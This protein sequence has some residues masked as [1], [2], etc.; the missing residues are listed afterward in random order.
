MYIIDIVF[1]FIYVA[2]C[3]FCIRETK[4]ITGNLISITNMF[5]IPYMLIC[6]FQEVICI[7][8]AYF[9]LPSY[10]YWFINS[11]F[12][13]LTYFTEI[14]LTKIFKPCSRDKCLSSYV[15][16]FAYNK[17]FLL[18]CSSIVLVV[19]LLSFKMVSNIDIALMLQDDFQGD[20]QDSAGGNFYIRLFTIIMAVYFWGIN[21]SRLGYIIGAICFVPHVV[22]NTKGILFIPII[23]MFLVRIMLGR[24]SNIKRTF[25]TLGCIGT[26]IFFSSYMMEFFTYG[27]NPLKDSDRWLYIFEKQVAYICSGVQEFA[28]NFQDGIEHNPNKINI[29]LVPYLNILAKFG[30]GESVSS[31]NEEFYR[32]IGT[33]PNYGKAFSNVNG[34]IGT[35]YLFNG[36]L[37]ALIYHIYMIILTFIIKVK[38]YSCKRPFWIVLYSLFLS[39]FALGWF[40]FYF[41]QTFWIYLVILIVIIDYIG[42]YFLI[43]K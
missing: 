9:I 41:M 13:F 32:S 17:F 10:G 42:K 22:V 36:L 16:T 11:L 3:L 2:V 40:D 43:N 19:A 25:I 30:I 35:L 24:I 26:L 23:S 21:K 18:G 14:L 15:E 31:I 6:I 27:E 20:F 28:V 8:N 1:F 7:F 12:V 4:K 39:G 33:L 37:G 5:V 38:T 34:Y 29:T